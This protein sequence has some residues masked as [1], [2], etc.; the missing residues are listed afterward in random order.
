MNNR[1]VGFAQK[2]KGAEF[3]STDFRDTRDEHTA[4]EHW[5]AVRGFVDPLTATD[6]HDLIHKGMSTRLFL[7]L[8]ASFDRVT[9]EDVYLVAG[10]SEKTAARRKDATLPREAADAAMAL[11][12]ITSLAEDVLG[13]HDNAEQWLVTPALGLDNRRPIELLS[14]R[15]G[16]EMV[17]TLLIRMDY[18]VYA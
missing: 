15:G 16:A 5:A 17:K 8:V 10:I 9:K 18:G 7:A 13:S 4:P 1:T 6:R 14:T 12:E 3:S 11:I 2:A